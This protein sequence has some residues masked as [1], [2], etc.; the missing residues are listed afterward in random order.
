MNGISSA[1]SPRKPRSWLPA[2]TAIVVTGV[3]G[4]VAV[5]GLASAALTDVAPYPR[6]GWLSAALYAQ[7]AL[8]ITAVTLLI[9]SRTMGRG[10]RVIARLG[11]VV[12]ALSVASITAATLLGNPA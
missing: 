7:A 9:L 2:L 1:T 8:G 11:W 10:H 12:T 4:L 5:A 3:C 6:M